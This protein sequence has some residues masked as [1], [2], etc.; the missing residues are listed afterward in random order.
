M[1]FDQLGFTY[2]PYDG[3]VV[4]YFKNLNSMNDLFFKAIIDKSNTLFSYVFSFA[5]PSHGKMILQNNHNLERV[6]QTFLGQFHHH[7]QCLTVFFH[8]PGVV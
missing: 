6:V 7:V 4:I 3:K 5:Y 8:H 1:D 2:K